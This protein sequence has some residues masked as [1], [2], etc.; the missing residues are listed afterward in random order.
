MQALMTASA[1]S[2]KTSVRY[3]GFWWRVLASLI[4]TAVLFGVYF[5]L[6]GA[7]RVLAPESMYAGPLTLNGK[8][9]VIDLALTL[10]PLM[11]LA[12]ICSAIG[13]AYFVVLES[14]PLRG[15]LGKAALGLYVADTFGDPISFYRAFA[16][17]ALK[18]LSSLVLCLGW[19]MPAF[20][21][22][23]QALHDVLAGTL[24]L[25]RTSYFVFGRQAPTEPGEH[26]DGTQ[27]V[28]SV[29]PRE[30]I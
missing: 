23:K 7:V 26:W 28:A 16:R 24:V 19:I 20:T 27:W 2:L 15:T 29:P 11:N 1:S 9:D 12:M 22:R 14:S 21:P 25:R 3:A 6:F 10:V 18:L 30:G 4:D 8:V 13:W 5:A 17:N